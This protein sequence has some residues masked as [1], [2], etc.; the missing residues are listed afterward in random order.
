MTITIVGLCVMTV[1]AVI[2][3]I[4]IIILA[5]PSTQEE[6]LWSKD[7]NAWIEIDHANDS[8]YMY[9]R[10]LLGSRKETIGC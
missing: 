3:L 1:I 8:V 2:E 5:S 7:L 6:W 4:A 10:K 9:K